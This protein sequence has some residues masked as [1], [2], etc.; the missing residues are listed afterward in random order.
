MMP[1][2]FQCSSLL[3]VN[4][5]DKNQVIE[6]WDQALAGD[7]AVI[8]LYNVKMGFLWK[9]QAHDPEANKVLDCVS[10]LSRAE[11]HEYWTFSQ[12]VHSQMEY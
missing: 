9:C 4:V 10:Q 8:F 12:S 3:L 5:N 11:V 1:V 7:L 6:A 2:R